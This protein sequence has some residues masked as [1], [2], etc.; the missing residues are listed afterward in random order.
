MTL[1]TFDFQRSFIGAAQQVHTFFL[2]A[3]I[4]IYYYYDVAGCREPILKI[5]RKQF[6]YP[7]Q[8][9]STRLYVFRCNAANI[10]SMLYDDDEFI[11]DYIIHIIRSLAQYPP[12]A[13][14]RKC[15][16]YLPTLKVENTTA[17]SGPTSVFDILYSLQVLTY[18]IPLLTLCC[19][20]NL[21]LKLTIKR[22]I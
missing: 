7:L 19:D 11:A 17:V 9:H 21:L 12:I 22:I 14:I 8:L 15:Q 2:P 18:I 1:T 3:I 16:L 20:L 6:F 4:I 10:Q 13:I 5:N